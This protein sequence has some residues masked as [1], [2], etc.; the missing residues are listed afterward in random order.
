MELLETTYRRFLEKSQDNK[1][2]S[3]WIDKNTITNLP[4]L[5]F[6]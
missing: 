3:I 4:Y 1:I 5:Y 2:A 6:A